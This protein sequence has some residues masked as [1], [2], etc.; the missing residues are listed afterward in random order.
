[1]QISKITSLAFGAK[2]TIIAP[3][4]LLSEDD[5]N[6]LKSL[7]SKIGTDKDSISI[8]LSDLQTTPINQ[9]VQAYRITRKARFEIGKSVHI[10]D[11]SKN[12]PYLHNGKELPHAVPKKYLVGVIKQIAQQYKL[13]K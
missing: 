12:V 10:I 4:T 13:Y 9:N 7:G 2:T 8:T 1:M 11:N 6:Y 5:K 3:S